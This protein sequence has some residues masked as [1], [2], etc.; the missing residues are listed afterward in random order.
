MHK[1]NVLLLLSTLTLSLWSPGCPRDRGAN[2]DSAGGETPSAAPAPT[3]SVLLIT[4]DTTRADPFGAYGG[5]AEATP[6]FDRLAARGALYRAAFCHTPLTIPS[7]STIL[8]GQYPYRHGVRDNGDAFLTD[9]AI[10]LA[11]LMSGAGYRT[12]ASVSAYVTNHKWGFGQGFDDYFDHIPANLEARG[13]LWQAERR[14]E[15]AVADLLGWIQKGDGAFFAW[16]HLFDPHDP[17]AAPEPY[18]SRF[19]DQPYLGE[20]AYTDAQI[21]AVV[22]T[23]ERLEVS[24]HT[25]LVVVGD[26]GEAFGNHG[27]H[28]HGVFLYNDT[29]RIPFLIRPAGGM[30]P[31]EI[32]EPVG[33]VDVMPTVL[34]LAGVEA[35]AGAVLDGV[36]LSGTLRGEL[37]ADRAL[38]GE[39]LYVRHHFGW[40]AQKM[41]VQWPYKYI[42]S[43]R[44]ELFDIASDPQ[45]Q[46][47]LSA[48]GAEHAQRLAAALAAH[49]EPTGTSAGAVDGRLAERL[50]ALGYVTS[51]VAVGDDEVLADP[52]D[53]LAVLGKLSRSNAALRRGELGEARGLL[54]AVVGEEPR[55]V[56][57]RVTLAKAEAQLGDLDAALAQLAEAERLAPDSTVVLG[58]HAEVLA[59]ARRPVEARAKLQRALEIDPANAR[60]WGQLLGLLFEARQYDE[61]LDQAERAE[62]AL[63]DA[64]LIHGY[65]GAALVA[66][67]QTE[68]AR[69]E[70]DLA[71][72]GGQEPPFAH[73][74]AG[75]LAESDGDREAALDQYLAEWSA[76]PEHAIALHAATLQA[77]MLQRNDEVL[78]LARTALAQDSQQPNLYWAQGQAQFNLGQ[79]DGAL[80]SADTCLELAANHPDCMMLRA[81]G[82]AKVGRR[83]EADAAFEL[84]VEL[85]RERHP[86]ATVEGLRQF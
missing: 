29:M 26:H 79:Y 81:N 12:A 14:G 47:D 27:E 80:R 83:V 40:S 71:L 68:A 23:L 7:H 21:G 65:R 33:L 84:A 28:H 78:E 19:P 60:T 70:L 64:P 42:G 34:A 13:N 61:V 25:A 9:E 46:Q 24:Q 50:E 6:A 32:H 63:G 67:G 48:A 5:T 35:P 18:A 2:P 22:E 16:L 38:Y 73:F 30:E 52:K 85:A 69:P 82:L 3:T 75:I 31:R 41:L 4:L 57:P 49:Q 17:Y 58:I 44:P 45:E 66:T 59:A 51:V 53:K 56:D 76:Y 15:L 77:I 8:T 36:D 1:P 62:Q 37:L 55:L 39:S 54:R 10:T 43:T 86:G 11:E 72:A 20:I 74:A